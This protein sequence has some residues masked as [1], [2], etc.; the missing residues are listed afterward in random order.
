MLTINIVLSAPS[1][2]VDVSENL[3]LDSFRYGAVLPDCPNACSSS[4]KL[5]RCPFFLHSVE[6]PNIFFSRNH[7]FWLFIWQEYT[8]WR[9]YQSFFLERISFLL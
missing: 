9:F 4:S 3:N 1:N 5:L 8:N 2:A 7:H 6:V